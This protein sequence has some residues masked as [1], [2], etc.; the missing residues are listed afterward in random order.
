MND[1]EELK[2]YIIL[3]DEAA[4]R[5]DQFFRCEADLIC[6]KEY[7]VFPSY[8]LAWEYARAISN[9]GNVKLKIT[10]LAFPRLKKMEGEL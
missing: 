3:V 6:Y 5:W 10:E 8:M 4:P 7:P 2:F 9:M 1:K